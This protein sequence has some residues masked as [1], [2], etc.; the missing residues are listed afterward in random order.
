M[1]S[2]TSIIVADDHPLYRK[3]LAEL[4]RSDSGMELVCEANDGEDALKAI[5]QHRPDVAVLDVEMPKLSG[6][7]IAKEVKLSEK[8]NVGLIMVTAYKDAEMFN[9]A[10]DLGVSGYVLKESAIHDILD[11]IRAVAKGEQYISPSLAGLLLKRRAATQTLRTETPG[12][13]QLTPTERKVLKLISIDRTSKEIAHSLGISPRTVENHRANIS[14]K[15]DIK[16]THS[17]LKFAF[18]HRSRL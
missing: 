12:I 14:R 2:L 18:Q 9:E 17:L 6:L 3:G 11:G 10:F 16:G 13:N 5:Q 1:T 8:L 7:E 4:V 15:L